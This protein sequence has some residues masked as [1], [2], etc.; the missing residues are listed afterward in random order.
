MPDAISPSS[1]SPSSATGFDPSLDEASQACR[2]DPPNSS[3]PE[4]L[5]SVQPAVAKLVSSV[6]KPAATLPA[7]SKTPAPST[8]NNN[9]QRTS[10]LSGIE[11]Y[12]AV[13][14]TAAS[15]SLYAGAALLKGREP[16]SGLE[17]EVLSASAQLGL[18]NEAQAGFQRIGGGTTAG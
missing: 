8:A 3:Q 12:A 13:G 5:A 17:V 4:T 1:C 15:D 14:K 9:A 2:G 7:A 6:P 18:Q 11:L 16:K 10:E